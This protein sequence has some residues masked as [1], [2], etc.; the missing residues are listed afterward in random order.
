MPKGKGRL[1]LFGKVPP[2]WPFPRG[3]E[4]KGRGAPQVR[5]EATRHFTRHLFGVFAVQDGKKASSD[6]PGTYPAHP[7][8]PAVFLVLEGTSPT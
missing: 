3:R 5:K 6:L 7:A 4:G 1:A 2:V 8:L